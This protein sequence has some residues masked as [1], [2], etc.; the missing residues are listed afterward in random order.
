MLPQVRSLK[1][2]AQ[3]GTGEV[4][5]ALAQGEQFKLERITSNG[6]ASPPDFW[7]E[8]EK[9]EWVALVAGEADLAFEEGNLSLK[10]GDFLTIPP[11]LKHRVL[12]TSSDAVWLALHFEATSSEK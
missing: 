10:A 9:P 2:T 8:Q 6:A 11:F 4:F 7:Y 1:D 3:A 12:S 5:T